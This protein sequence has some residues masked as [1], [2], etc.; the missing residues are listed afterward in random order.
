MYAQFERFEIK[1]TLN[2]AHSANHGGDCL[3]DV[4]EL[5]KLPMIKRQVSRINDE[6]L[7]AE[8]S[9]QGGWSDNE[10]ANRQDNEERIVWLAACNISEEADNLKAEQEDKLNRRK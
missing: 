4:L 5:L 7:I 10:L 6:K 1:M 8:L 9:E 2:Q 3:P